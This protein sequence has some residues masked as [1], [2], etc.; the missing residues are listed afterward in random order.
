[1]L[2]PQLSIII[3]TYNRK[4]VL[5]KALEGYRHQTALAEILEILVVDDGS[6]DGTEA[7]VAAFSQTSPITIRYHPRQNSGQ[8]AA[9]NSGI[10][11]AIGRV[12]LFT[13]DDIIPRPT[14]VAEH[15]AW[16]QKY[17]GDN[18]AIL[19]KV[20]WS[21]E[22]HPTPFMEW[23]GLSGAL[24]GYGH[25]SPGNEAGF[26]DLYTCNL[27]VKREFLMNFGLFDESFRGYGYED[28]ELGCRLARKGFR[29]IYND[30]A[31]GE[32]YKRMSYADACRREESI[33]RAAVRLET[34]EGGRYLKEQASHAKPFSP[35]LR[36]RKAL[37]KVVAPFLVRLVPLLDT[38][39]RLPWIIY[40]ILY[41][42]HV[43]PKAQ[44]NFDRS[45]PPREDA[46]GT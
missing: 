30:A 29:M 14:L 11:A 17:P 32:H 20:V 10:R 22:L 21:P 24:F 35:K 36:L 43:V 44:A 45:R 42:H 9:R 34:T 13:D 41:Y 8:A 46:K 16:H 6:T 28:L 33:C 18:F 5:L 37:A 12:L 2:T 4:E 15:T 26:A 40:R 7:A 1:L 25:L 3:P 19:G 39:V 23:L 38:Q 31:I 27:S